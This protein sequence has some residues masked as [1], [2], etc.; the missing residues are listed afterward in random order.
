MAKFNIEGTWYDETDYK[1]A[2][3]KHLKA[4]AA[5]S[6]S[7]PGTTVAPGKPTVA[8]VKPPG[9]VVSNTPVKPPAPVKVPTTTSPAKPAV[10]VTTG[11]AT[12]FDMVC[13][14]GE[15]NN[16]WSPPEQRLI[17]GM[18]VYQPWNLEAGINSMNGLWE[19]LR[20][21]MKK[22]GFGK[23]NAFAQYLR[24]QGR[25]FAVATARTESGAYT[26]EYNYVIKIP[27]A[28]TFLWGP[29][30]TLGPQVN[31][32]KP[33]STI[34]ADY[35]VLN[36]NSIAE[37]TVLAFGHKCGT[38]EVTFVHDLQIEFVASCNGKPVSELAIKQES[39]LSF[40]DKIKLRRYLRRSKSWLG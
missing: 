18:T 29:D 22:N 1:T 34:T 14:R 8:Q 6:L 13:Y 25:P 24:A 10:A 23:P 12:A 27:N 3:E 31:F 32:A 19:K 5:G 16:W 40:D 4:K 28:R 38:Y 36:A 11:P 26:Y 39:D 35:V 2:R 15:K 7:K 17:Y 33:D 30:L 9:P 20:D 21:H 37:S